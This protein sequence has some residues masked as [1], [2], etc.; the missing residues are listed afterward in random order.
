VTGD[1][2]AF[3]A[4]APLASV[5]T[6]V[7]DRGALFEPI[8]DEELVSGRALHVHVVGCV[9]GAVR[10]NHVHYQ[11]TER[12]CV[13]AGEFEVAVHDVQS[14]ANAS[15]ILSPQRPMVVTMRPG[16]AHAFRNIGTENGYLLA[17][18]DAVFDPDDVHPCVLL[19]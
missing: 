9:P 6:L 16:V 18:S 13:V 10:A 17:Y 7:D 8:P 14:S 2:D 12:L 15:I 4:I 5:S 3:S 11:Q 1:V 19:A